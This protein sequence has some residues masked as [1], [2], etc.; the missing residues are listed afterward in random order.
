MATHTQHIYLMSNVCPNQLSVYRFQPPYVWHPCSSW[1][2]PSYRLV[3]HASYF[4][5]AESIKPD[6]QQHYADFHMWSNCKQLLSTKITKATKKRLRAPS[7]MFISAALF[8]SHNNGMALNRTVHFYMHRLI[9][10]ST[11]LRLDFQIKR[12][13]HTKNKPMR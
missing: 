6:K 1:S 11:R 10:G 7:V 3:Y 2:T 5:C 12:T 13:V 9:Q 8:I 4:I